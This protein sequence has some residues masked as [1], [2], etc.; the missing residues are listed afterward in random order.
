MLLNGPNIIIGEFNSSGWN[1]YNEI[2]KSNIT[3]QPLKNP[4]IIKGTLTYL[5]KEYDIISNEIIRNYN[6]LKN[7]NYQLVYIPKEGYIGI[8]LLYINYNI[9][10]INNNKMSFNI[11]IIDTNS[12]NI[13]QGKI[14]LILS[15]SAINSL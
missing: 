4:D 2:I 7:F 1:N 12:S 8:L 14:D 13:H 10:E 6:E 15:N 3:F 5:D 11:K 9:I